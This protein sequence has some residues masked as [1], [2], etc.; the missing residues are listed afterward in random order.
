MN[1]LSLIM[2]LFGR[3][4][5]AL[6]GVRKVLHLLV[7]LVLTVF[8]LAVLAPDETRVP[9]EAALILAPE[10]ALVEQLSGDR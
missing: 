7:L 6:D 4:W 8:V 5:R 3:I 10:G 2:K 1:P 9:S